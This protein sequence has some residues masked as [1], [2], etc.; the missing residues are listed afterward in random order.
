M[1]I[2]YSVRYTILTRAYSPAGPVK[3]VP[4]AGGGVNLG[5]QSEF[6]TIIWAMGV[7][8]RVESQ[9]PEGLGSA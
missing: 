7:Q 5:D 4:S 6:Q 9:A 3:T 8:Y 2:Q 1:E